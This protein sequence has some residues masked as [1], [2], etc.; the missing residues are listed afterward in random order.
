VTSEISE[1]G[2]ALQAR[3]WHPKRRL[4]KSQPRIQLHSFAGKCSR[5]LQSRAVFPMLKASKCKWNNQR[6]LSEE[7][8]RKET[9]RDWAFDVHGLF[10]AFWAFLLGF[11]AAVGGESGRW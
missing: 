2:D 11:L 4:R 8:A 5:G 10:A 7:E 6:R 1:R 9:A 3:V